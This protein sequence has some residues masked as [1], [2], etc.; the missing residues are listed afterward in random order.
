MNEALHI[1]TDEELKNLQQIELEM[2]LEIDRIC[3]SNDIKYSVDGGSLLGAV[4]HKGFIPWDDD[5]DVIMLRHEYARFKRACRQELDK[6]RFF[7]QDYRTDPEY[8][9]GWAKLRR[10]DTSYIRAGQENQ[11][12]QDGIFLDIFV[13]D[14][15]PDGWLSRRLHYLACFVIRKGLYSVVGRNN[16]PN[17]VIRKIYEFMSLIPK[18]TY[19]KA[20]NALAKS[21]HGKRTELI[22]HYMYHYPK[23]CLYGLPRVCFDEMI[24]M[25][26]EGYIVRGF[27]E[28]D[29][30]LT[31][32]YGDYMKLPPK[33]Q[34]VPKMEIT[35]IKLTDP[36]LP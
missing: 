24:D 30:Y 27:K 1:I 10:K 20:R 18:N 12:Y 15:V 17:P 2:L 16:E 32:L 14:N 21:L 3:R 28:Y 22:S 13:V 5:A 31:K 35:S 11:N 4:R 19:F 6:D 8:R 34:Q 36:V 23:R 26:F 25:D 29:L 33:E 9:W 7:L